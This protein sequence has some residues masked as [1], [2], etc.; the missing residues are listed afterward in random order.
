MSDDGLFRVFDRRTGELLSTTLTE[1]GAY[2]AAQNNGWRIV[3]TIPARAATEVP[4][5]RQTPRFL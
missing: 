5:M 4:D 1:A 3:G 2:T